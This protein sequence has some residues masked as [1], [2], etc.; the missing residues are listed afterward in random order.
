MS[1]LLTSDL[2]LSERSGFGM[3]AHIQ[4]QGDVRVGL[5]QW[6]GRSESGVAIEGFQLA[7]LSEYPIRDVRYRA[8]LSDGIWSEWVN[9]TEFC[10]SRG[11][12]R[13][14][15]GYEVRLE[16]FAQVRFVL[17]CSARFADG[18]E[19]RQ[20]TEGVCSSS[21]GAPL[22]AMQILL[23]ESGC[24]HLWG[25]ATTTHVICQKCRKLERVLPDFLS[26]E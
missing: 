7:L 12:G 5:H 22:E 8:L 25:G 14:L 11:L 4:G 26:Y 15:L 10:G 9:A 3:L 17:T 24:D 1:T 2:Q 18:S 20:T 13:P 19:V 23:F 16:G 21:K 6:A